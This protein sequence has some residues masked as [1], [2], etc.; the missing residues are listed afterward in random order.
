[1][2]KRENRGGVA[3]QRQKALEEMSPKLQDLA[4]QIDRKVKTADR[5]NVLIAHAIGELLAHATEKEGIFDSKPLE[6]IAQYIVIPGGD[7]TLATYRHLAVTFDR[8]FIEA[9]L[10]KP[11][12][13]GQLLTVSHFVEVSTIAQPEVRREILD[14]IRRECISIADLRDELVT[15]G[16]RSSIKKG[17]GR[18]KA[19]RP[20]SPLAG[21]HRFSAQA[22][23]VVDYAGVLTQVF[24]EIQEMPPAEVSKEL[25]NEVEN[26]E[27]AAANAIE[28]LQTLMQ[29]LKGAKDRVLRIL[30]ARKKK[31]LPQPA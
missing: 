21:L 6:R 5:G 24:A 31:P 14:W 2:S 11:L 19:K 17:G 8:P 3:A 27:S 26:A 28:Q 13:N 29:Q 30:A 7:R 16:L 4:K 18:R 1:M 10:A 9:E 22:Q 12:A 23:Q 15:R 25:R 20:V